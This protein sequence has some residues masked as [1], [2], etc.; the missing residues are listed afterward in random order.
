MS[1][2]TDIA[3]LNLWAVAAKALAV[4]LI[5]G[6]LVFGGYKWGASSCVAAVAAQTTV[7]VQAQHAQD[8]KQ[9]TAAAAASTVATRDAEV[10][11]IATTTIIKEIH[12]K[13]TIITQK[14]DCP[15]DPAID[16]SVLDLY[17][18]AGK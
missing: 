18:K 17:N 13:P 15:A 5:A 1:I 2:L 8:A 12:D 16:Q 3:G 6:A 7:A 14:I 10:K 9:H 11:K 4:L